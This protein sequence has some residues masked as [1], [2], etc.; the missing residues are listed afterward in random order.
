MKFD[1]YCDEAMPDLFT[2]Q[3]PPAKYLMIGGLWLPSSLRDEAKEKIK[4]L[5]AQYDVWG[6][7]K[8][9]KVSP[10]KLD[11]YLSLVDLFMGYGMDMR[12]R[13]I[14][15]DHTQV[16]MGMHANDGELGFYK[17]YYQLLH[18][19][20]LDRNEYYIFSDT[21]S[22]RSLRRLKDLERC[23]NHANLL[24]S[25]EN[26]QALP[27]RQVALIQLCDLLLG[28]A[29]SR[30]NK[31]LNPGSAKEAVVKRLESHLNISEITP[32]GR[33]KEKYNVFRILLGGGW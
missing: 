20:I 6:E 8:W 27:S 9:T 33:G 16:N 12:F 32:T 28:A 26:L 23:L 1:I 13:C 31:T 17:F 2:S 18:H 10:N 19:W 29:S 4:S 24:S 22:N 11:F 5:R 25:V 21:K 14:A 15:V 30:L 7:I 3:N